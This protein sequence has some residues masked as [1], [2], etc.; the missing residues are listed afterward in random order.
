LVVTI[1]P[2]EVSILRK[3]IEN[4]ATINLRNLGYPAISAFDHF[5][6]KGI[7]Y[8]GEE[9]TYNKLCNS[10]IDIVLT[11]AFIH[12]TK[13]KS[14]GSEGSLLYPGSYYYNRTGI[15]DPST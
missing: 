1:L 10:G 13:E 3:Q 15:A 6:A 7:A 11:L 5:G 9:A 4:E 2:E 8:M 12:K 14:Y